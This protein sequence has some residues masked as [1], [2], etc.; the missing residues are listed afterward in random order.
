M[1]AIGALVGTLPYMAPEQFENPHRVD[2]RADIYAF[3]VVLYSMI[4]GT[5]PFRGGSLA[6]WRRQHASHPP[7]SVVPAIPR[8][9]RHAA[10]AVD[11]LVGRCLAKAP[12]DRFAT[13]P[14][15][16]RVLAQLRD[17]VERPPRW[18]W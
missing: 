5:L 17:D 9:Y 6:R 10:G 7:P 15:L 1:T 3:G 11:R 16:R 4:S 13:I 14:E 2:A 12:A 8:K 18:P